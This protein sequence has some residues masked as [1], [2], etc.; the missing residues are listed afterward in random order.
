MT[1]SAVVVL[2]TRSCDGKQYVLLQRRKNTGFADGLWDLSCSGHV[3]ENE[4]MTSACVRECAEELGIIVRAEDC[5]FI[6]L[7]HKRDREFDL[8]YYNGYFEISQFNGEPRICESDKCS[9][10][11]WF[12]LNHL[13]VD[14]IP[15]RAVAV[16]AYL[17]GQSYSEFGWK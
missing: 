16:K 3:E 2:L 6:A 8:T 7:I 14:I 13:P 5:E 1:P 4:S 10:M 17:S 9:E 11:A 12:E 15:D